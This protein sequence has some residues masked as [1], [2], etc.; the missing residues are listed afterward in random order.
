MTTQNVSKYPEHPL[1]QI[2]PL[3][4]EKDL[5]VLADDIKRNG[6][7]APVTLLDKQ[8]LDGRN[9]EKAC[10]M[11]GV[12]PRYRDFNGTGDPLD[13]VISA[14]VSRRHLTTSQRATVAAKIANLKHGQKKSDSSFELS[15]AVSIADA[16]AQLNVS[17]AGVKRA[18]EV[19][20]KASP[21][22]LDAIEQGRKTVGKVAAEMKSKSAKT[23]PDAPD[24]PPAPEEQVDKTGYAIPDSI[25]PDW[26]RATE[27]SREMLSQISKLKL[28]LKS[29]L[30]EKDVIFAEVT[31]TSIAD[32]TNA[33]TSIK[34]V[35][36]YAVCTTCQ[37]HHRKRCNLCRGRGFLSEFAWRSFVPSEIKAIRGGR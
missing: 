11:A 9:R 6:L 10:F 14:N 2:M 4:A 31:N 26:E 18:K 35:V 21:E 1:S 7:R 25:L 37:G 17:Q 27:T 24:T 32:F 15:Q 16:A 8:I 33:Y 29:G 3:M 12:E 23:T 36:P 19:I 30:D 13:F 20:K 28:Q 22:D 5:Q 34:C